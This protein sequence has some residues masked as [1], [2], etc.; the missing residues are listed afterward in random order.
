[1]KSYELLDE[2][3][4]VVGAKQVAADLNLSTSLVYKW[5]APPDMDSGALNPLE[6]IVQLCKSTR[7][8]RP[9]E[10]VCQQ[11]AGYFVANLDVEPV[12]TDAEIL[13]ETQELLSRFSAV[14]HT[15]SESIAT[16]GIIDVIEAAR[17][18]ETWCQLQSRGEAF[19]RSCEGGV[20]DRRTPR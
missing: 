19:V 7:S 13:H 17:I 2:V 12:S 15:L 4:R 8:T 18:R 10:W 20:F 1:M 14:L 5:C 11:L 16:D 9:I 6:R 3:V